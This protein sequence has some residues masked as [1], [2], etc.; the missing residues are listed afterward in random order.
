MLI[1]YGVPLASIEYL[2]AMK[3]GAKSRL[4]WGQLRRSGTV[5]FRFSLESGTIILC[6]LSTLLTVIYA[7][8]PTWRLH[9]EV[10]PLTFTEAKFF[11]VFAHGFVAGASGPM[12]LFLVKLGV[13]FCVVFRKAL[14]R[15][16][17]GTVIGFALCR[18]LPRPC[19]G[20]GSDSDCLGSSA[21]GV[22]RNGHRIPLGARALFCTLA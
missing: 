6:A 5:L 9:L 19:A 20:K 14:W 12:G 18:R 2:L 13:Y 8:A 11:G 1:F 22:V 4:R 10:T 17:R 3:S 16:S 15:R 7:F 21:A